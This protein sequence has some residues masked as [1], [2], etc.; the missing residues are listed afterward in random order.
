MK[1]KVYQVSYQFYLLP[2]IKVTYNR[3]LNGYYEFIVGWFNREV[4]LEL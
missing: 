3:R 4:T 1:I 2:Y